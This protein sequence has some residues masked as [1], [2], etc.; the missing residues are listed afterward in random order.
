M[1]F[2]SITVLVFFIML[3]SYK[4][5]KDKQK[6][7]KR[8]SQNDLNMQLLKLEHQVELLNK[9]I[10]LTRGQAII[11]ETEIAFLDESIKLQ[12]QNLSQ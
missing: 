9:D 12:K 2:I 6:N 11:I 1:T 8:I 3:L 7:I 10:E 4:V 5:Y